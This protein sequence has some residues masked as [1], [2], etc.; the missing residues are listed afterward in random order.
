MD[1]RDRGFFPS[2]SQSNFR[3]GNALSDMRF[4]R[5]SDVSS[6]TDGFVTD[7]RRVLRKS[8]SKVGC[9]RARRIFLGFRESWCRVGEILT[10]FRSNGRRGGWIARLSHHTWS[11]VPW[12][13]VRGF[14]RMNPHARSIGKWAT[15][16]KAFN[17]YA[18]SQA[19]LSGNVHC[20][21]CDSPPH[22]LSDSRNEFGGAVSQFS[23]LAIVWACRLRIMRV[24]R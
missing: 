1:S 18:G 3:G 4:C 17:R 20:I 7:W 16:Q 2:Q 23:R 5:F 10:S 15:T 11:R 21:G 8:I 19:L 6:P 14:R 24:S 13:F 22:D 9:A 12:Q